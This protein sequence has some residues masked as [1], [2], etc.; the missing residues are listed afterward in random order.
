METVLLRALARATLVSLSVLSLEY[1][2]GA[3]DGIA[4]EIM[5][6]TVVS[7]RSS[8]GH[9]TNSDVFKWSCQSFRTIDDFLGVWRPCNLDGSLQA[10]V[11]AQSRSQARP[12]LSG[13]W[14]HP[15]ADDL[16]RDPPGKG[17]ILR[18]E[19]HLSSFSRTIAWSPDANN[20]C[21]VRGAPLLL[22]AVFF[23]T[24]GAHR[25]GFRR[26]YVG[27]TGCRRLGW[28]WVQDEREL[29]CIPQFVAVHD[30]DERVSTIVWETGTRHGEVQCLERV[31]TQ[32]KLSNSKSYVLAVG[33]EDKS[34]SDL[35]RPGRCWKLQQKISKTK[36][37]GPTVA[38]SRSSERCCGY[39]KRRVNDAEHHNLLHT[40]RVSLY[41][42][43]ELLMILVDVPMQTSIGV[44]DEV[45]KLFGTR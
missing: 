18:H 19:H 23:E 30:W 17:E 5:D 33:S 20:V 1:F 42:N 16:L 4:V 36:V 27:R 9:K 14:P 7:S 21:E 32:T 11:A 25:D 43:V 12:I 31:F 2:D 37:C 39:P 38:G 35:G 15:L 10:A 22:V 34:C 45:A 44:L 8:S 24:H 3:M 6:S 41:A 26:R 29:G 28:T 40:H 13:H